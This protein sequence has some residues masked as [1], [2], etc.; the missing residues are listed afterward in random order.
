VHPTGINSIVVADTSILINLSHTGH[1]PLLG[2]AA[3]LRFV[4]PDE[5]VAEI[6][7]PYQMQALDAAL[8]DGLII[9]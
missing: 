4:V 8:A 1:L 7:E 5:V 6:A 9:R 2:C 3:G